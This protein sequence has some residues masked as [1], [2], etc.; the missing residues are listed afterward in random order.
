MTL[1][2][3][4]LVVGV[5][6][7]CIYGLIALGLVL[8]YKGSRVLNFAQAEI[9][10]ACLYVAYEL[11]GTKTLHLPYLAGAA[12]AVLVAVVIGLLFEWLVVSRMGSAPRLSVAVA[13]IGLFTFLFFSEI[14][15]FGPSPYYLPP[16]ITGH[17]LQVVGV[18]ISPTQLVAFGVIGVVGLALAA[19][20]RYTDF[21]LAIL[22]AAQDPTAVRLIGVPLRRVSMFTWGAAAGLSA[23]AALLIEPTITVIAPG[24]IG[25][26]LLIGGL[27]AALLGGLTS[28]PGAFVGGIIIG[29]LNTEFQFAFGGSGFPGIPALDLFV[30]VVLVL[31][32]RPQ[33]LLGSR[34]LRA[35]ASSS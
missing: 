9:G 25:E 26:P 27:A 29:I 28:L 6:T 5:V 17:G 4:G 12:A 34:A 32:V 7:G 20:L 14:Y 1:F 24:V 23:I 22:A 10:T 3:A 21:G 30:I 2:L 11:S 16:P 31:L 19:F 13:T 8:V 15:L 35:E 18:F 33:G